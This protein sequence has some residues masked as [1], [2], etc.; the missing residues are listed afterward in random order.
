MISMK[1]ILHLNTSCISRKDIFTMSEAF[2]WMYTHMA[3]LVDQQLHYMG[4]H[5]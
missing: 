3:T 5:I 2:I 1:A 4:I